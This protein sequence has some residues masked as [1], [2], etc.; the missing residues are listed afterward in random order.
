MQLHIRM[1]LYVDNNIWL[2]SSHSFVD[3]DGKPRVVAVDSEPKV[4]KKISRNLSL[5]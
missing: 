1:T 5:R 3:Q 4:I 2:F